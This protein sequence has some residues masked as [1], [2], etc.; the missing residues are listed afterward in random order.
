MNLH[1][2]LYLTFDCISD[3][4]PFFQVPH[5]S[6]TF[7]PLHSFLSHSPHLPHPLSPRT[8]MLLPRL[9]VSKFGLSSVTSHLKFPLVAVDTFTSST[10]V[11]VLSSRCSRARAGQGRVRAGEGRAR[12]SLGTERQ[13][14]T[15][16]SRAGE[17]TID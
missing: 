15:K 17:T 2:L 1:S 8:V 9:W 16:Q 13:G 3:I 14:K 10:L 11:P 7:A 12:A 5:S 6:Y 4:N